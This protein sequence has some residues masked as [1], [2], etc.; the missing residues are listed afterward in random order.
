[1]SETGFS[2]RRFFRGAGVAGTV[3]VVPLVSGYVGYR[4]PQSKPEPQVLPPPKAEE[5]HS[6]YS[7]PDLRPPKVKMSDA[8]PD[9]APPASPRHLLLGVKDYQGEGAGQAGM[10]IV[11]RR[12]EPV[13]FNVRDGDDE[14]PMDFRMQTYRG[15]P[16]L[17]TWQGA[18][19]SGFGIGKGIVFD[20]AYRQIAEVNTGNGVADADLHEFLITDR[21]TALIMA[22]NP[23]RADLRPVGGPADGWVSDGV[24]QEID[25]ESGE[26]LFDWRSLD[27]VDLAESQ[28]PVE[29]QG[30]EDQPYD[31]IHLNSI[32]LD[33]DGDLLVSARNTW[34]VY[35]IAK[36]DGALRWTLGGKNSDFRLGD[37]V[38]FAWQ[39]DARRQPDG[40]LS[41]FDNAASP[42]QANRS[43]GL[44]LALNEDAMTAAV[45]REYTHPAGLLCDNQGNL[46]LLDDGRAIVGWGCQPFTSEF[47]ADGEWL[48]DWRTPEFVQ[49]YRAYMGDW[50]GRPDDEPAVAVRRNAARGV[51][52]YASWN[53]ATEVKRWRV[54]AGKRADE[55]SAVVT[56]PRGGFETAIS[57]D[58]DGPFFAVAALD[59]QGNELGRSEPVRGR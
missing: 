58:A 59:K 57:C 2:R 26:V 19:P 29:G 49:S 16:V 47:D 56:V 11:N 22:Y 48:T 45:D 40:T 6:F 24:I 41:L 7:R 36:S 46:Q 54:L 37:G 32:G 30:T 13:W 35:K 1:M 50:V 5:V 8:D 18:A 39:H 34:A 12:G 43:R 9:T 53:G 17:T 4:I 52:V 55:L 42:P 44:V 14:K 25:I 15:E 10:L 51:L 3:A 23:V 20:Q 33:D 38:E 28:H 27:H 31:Y 21:D